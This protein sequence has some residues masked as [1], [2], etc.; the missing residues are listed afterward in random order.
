MRPGIWAGLVLGLVVVAAALVLRS[1]RGAAPVTGE[2]LSAA[3][4]ARYYPPA[5]PSE[6]ALQV[7]HLGHS[8]VGRDM[9]AMLAQL[10]GHGWN[11]QLG[12]GAS[13]NQ[14]LQGE[15][16]GFA[17]ENTSPA[18]RPAGEAIDSADYPVVVLTEMVDL[19]D[20]IRYHDSAAVFQ[21]WVT[22]IRAARPDARIYLYETW[23]D[24]ALSAQ[25]AGGWS[26]RIRADLPALWEGVLLRAT[27]QEGAGPVRLIPGGQ[28]MLAFEA[29]AARGEIPG[30]G[31]AADLFSDQIHFNDS[32]AYLMALTH[33]A[34][35]RGRSPEGLPFALNRADGSPA[36]APEAAAALAMQRLV[37]QVVTSLPLTGV[38]AGPG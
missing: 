26:G 2:A 19:G 20:A 37:W 28:V 17:E 38:S 21:A 5:M 32:G 36:K 10:S 4:I 29:A 33:Y 34:V 35:I 31:S 8:L 14:H 12:W 11:S 16:P 3:E 27:L 7:Y 13:L 24:R 6:G 22:R 15:V 23:H 9:P 30:Y 18:F 25:L 1:W